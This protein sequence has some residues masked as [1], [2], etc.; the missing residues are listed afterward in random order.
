MNNATKRV[1]VLLL[2]LALVATACGGDDDT[3]DP[4][5]ATSSGSSS[6]TTDAPATTAAPATTMPAALDPAQVVAE[7]MIPLQPDT[8]LVSAEEADGGFRVG[9]TVDAP[10]PPGYAATATAAG[11][12]VL[13]VRFG[14]ET[15][16]AALGDLLYCLV[17]YANYDSSS[18]PDYWMWFWFATGLTA[19]DCLAAG[20]RIGATL[21]LLGRPS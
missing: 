19:E 20:E 4:T 11:W 5:T 8:E 1:L 12:T 2:G 17:A 15:T 7:H 10:P 18:S 21:S 16:I 13:D 6:A 14:S 3:A 9:A